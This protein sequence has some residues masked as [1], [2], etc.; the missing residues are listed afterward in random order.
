MDN[1]ITILGSTGSIGR[2]T[3]EVA[4]H[5]G[6]KIRALSANNSIDLLEQQLRKYDP[7]LVAVFDEKAAEALKKRISDKNTRITQGIEG[8]IE[9]AQT[10]GADIIVTAIAGMAG[11]EPTLAALRTGKRIALANKEPLVCAGEQVMQTARNYRAEIIPVDSEH[12]AIFQCLAE[13]RLQR[14]EGYP[15]EE[16]CLQNNSNHGHAAGGHSETVSSRAERPARSDAGSFKDS[17]ENE[18]VVTYASGRPVSECSPVGCPWVAIL[19]KR[20]SAKHWKIAECSESTGIIS[21]P[22]LR[23]VCMT[24]SPAQTSGSLFARATRLPVL[25]AARVGSRPAMPAIAVT[26]MSAPLD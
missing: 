5:L 19:R 3:L 10:S 17:A 23:A 25:S 24:C 16:F 12:S 11:L 9:V 18:S 14:C 26:I 15:T 2:Q 6:A 7:E 8:Q 4:D 20:T 1:G 21:A 13:I 22:Y